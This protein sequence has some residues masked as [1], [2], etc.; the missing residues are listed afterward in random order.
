MIGDSLG[1]PLEGKRGNSL[2]AMGYVRDMIDAPRRRGIRRAGTYTDD[3]QMAI[4]LA[5]ALLDTPGMVDLD[6][7]AARFAENLDT[8]RGYGGTA[9]KILKAVKAG[10]PWREAVAANPLPGG[11][12]FKNGAA[13]RVA[14]V[15]L[16][17]YSDLKLVAAAAEQQAEVT[18][19]MHP[20]ALFGARLQALAVLRGIERG[21]AGAP[22]DGESFISGLLPGAPDEF[23]K[24]LVWIMK[25]TV[26]N[27]D[28]AAERIG[29][30]S[31]AWTSVPMALWG[32]LSCQEDPEEAIIGVV[33]LGGDADTIGAM[34]GAIAGAYHGADAFPER[35]VETLENG[36]KGRDYL[37]GLADR[38]F[39]QNRV[40]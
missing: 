38:L 40:Q 39:E 11:G 7:L 1:M 8:S 9:R 13:M 14:P 22:F 24:R 28:E 20:M 35:W 5:E 19:H 16:A 36:E 31:H 21:A 29:T 4:G 18:G 10:V 26:A 37:L 25:H 23:E 2:A 34:T 33:N 6:R 27:P 17:F 30:S 12:S 3:T 32:F 15:A